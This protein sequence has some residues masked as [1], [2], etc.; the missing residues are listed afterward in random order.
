MD[1]NKII[2]TNWHDAQQIKRSDVKLLWH[3]DYYD[4]PL[5]G[6]LLFNEEKYWFKAIDGIPG[7]SQNYIVIRLTPE[8]L[9]EEEKW[10]KL[11]QDHV[12]SQ[13]DYDENE[14]RKGL[15]KPQEMWNK[16]YEPRKSYIKLD[17][18]NN[19]VVAWFNW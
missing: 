4:G 11:F 7:Y 16:F 1:L 5:S 18:S 8:Q 9:N 19:E 6:L 12:G 3:S 2:L 14:K 10:H 13:T 15:V 17:I